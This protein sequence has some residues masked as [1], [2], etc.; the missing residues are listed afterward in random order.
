MALEIINDHADRAIANLLVQFK[1]RPNIEAVLRVVVGKVQEIE[2]AFWQLLTERLLGEAVGSQLDVI[3][4]IIG[5]DRGPLDDDVYRGVLRGKVAANLSSG[6]WAEVVHV[7]ALCVNSVIVGS[8]VEGVPEYPA[9]GTIRITSTPLVEGIGPH[10]ADLVALAESSG[11]RI[12]FQYYEGDYVFGFDAPDTNLCVNPSFEAGDINWA[13]LGGISIIDDPANARTLKWVSKWVSPS[14]GEQSITSEQ[15]SVVH[16]FDYV[17]SIWL[18]GSDTADSAVYVTIRWYDSDGVFIS[19]DSSALT[20]WSLTWVP[21]SVSAIAP[22]KAVAAEIKIIRPVAEEDILY[23]DDVEF[24]TNGP[25]F[26][27]VYGFTTT[28][29]GT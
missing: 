3:G 22:P 17:A 2:I 23:V 5:R 20:G 29:E 7:V 24:I 9:A 11:V 1:D 12:L 16:G 25:C 6:T 27:G 14:Y 4:R 13:K 19:D 15:I 26:D 8:Y 18:K 10:V 28:V 21:A